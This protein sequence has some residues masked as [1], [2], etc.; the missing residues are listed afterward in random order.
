MVVRPLLLNHS[1]SFQSLVSR[2]VDLGGIPGLRV[3]LD[4]FSLV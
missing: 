4:S 1:I 2:P 3:S